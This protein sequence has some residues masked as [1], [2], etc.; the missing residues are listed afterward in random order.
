MQDGACLACCSLRGTSPFIGQISTNAKIRDNRTYEEIG[1]VNPANSPTAIDTDS[2]PSRARVLDSKHHLERDGN[3]LLTTKETP[4][5]KYKFENLVL[6]QDYLNY[7]N[8]YRYP[9]DILF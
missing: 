1:H 6:N 2:T 7:W 9:T 8:H 4:K 3:P 5:N